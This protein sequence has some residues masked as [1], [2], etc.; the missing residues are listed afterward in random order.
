MRNNRRENRRDVT[1]AQSELV[2]IILILG[3]TLVSISVIFLLAQPI[4]SDATDRATLDRVENEFMTLDSRFT[5]ASV[6][7]SANESLSLSL[8]GDSS[9]PNPTQLT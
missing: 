6:G 5:A 2:G 3:I 7:S 1:R 9:S 4:V 8:E